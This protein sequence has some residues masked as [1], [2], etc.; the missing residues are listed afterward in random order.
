MSP[1]IVRDATTS[2]ADAIARV[3]VDAWQTSYRGIMPEDVLEGFTF[4]AR[5]ARWRKNL[6]E[7]IAVNVVAED[8]EGTVIGFGCG[9]TCRHEGSGYGGELYALYVH[10]DRQR[11]GA[12]GALLAAVARGLLAAGFRDMML[13]V[14][15]DNVNARRFYEASGGVELGELIHPVGEHGLR[16][17][18]YGWPELAPLAR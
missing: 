10:P 15:A 13:H 16:A 12:G 5:S 14:L 18:A 1:V 6:S 2:D 8:A 17:V 11:R 9:G 7:P 3:Q 4:E